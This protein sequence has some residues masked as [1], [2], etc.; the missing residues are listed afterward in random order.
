MGPGLALLVHGYE[1]HKPW[2]CLWEKP[3]DTFRRQ[4]S[5]S[6]SLQLFRRQPS[7]VP[8]Q[9]GH[10]HTSSRIIRQNCKRWTGSK[11]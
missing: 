1:Q 11:A 8:S 9:P 6:H 4:A 5:H 3:R 10:V 7:L 2:C